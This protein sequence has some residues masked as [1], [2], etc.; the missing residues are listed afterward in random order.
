MRYIV[1]FV[2]QAWVVFDRHQFR[3]V[4]VHSLKKI[5]EGTAVRRNAERK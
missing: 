5:A 1:N 2:N 4:S 3:N